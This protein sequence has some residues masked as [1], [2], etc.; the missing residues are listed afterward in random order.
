MG[1]ARCT[2]NGGLKTN[3]WKEVIT[4]LD[5]SI[6]KIQELEE[7]TSTGRTIPQD[8]HLVIGEGK[9]LS[10]AVMYIDIC[11]YSG[12]PA[13]NFLE[14]A[15][16][17]NIFNLF[18]SEMVR[19]ARDYG[20]EIEK[21][22]GDGLLIYF[23]PQSGENETEL[24]KRS[25]A[26]GLTMLACTKNLINLI[27]RGSGFQEVHFRIGM[28]FG[29]VTIAKVGSARLFN[30]RVVI[31]AIANVASKML[32]F[33]GNDE[34][35]IGGEFL[36]RLPQGW[37][38]HASLITYNSGFIYKLTGALYPIYRYNGRWLKLND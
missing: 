11:N 25:L 10:V 12:W 21:N 29:P 32:K 18:L 7:A 8:E 27:L 24:C 38:Q 33:G 22:T 14:Q 15:D 31:G 34:V 30:S 37:S 36:K 2:G 4:R 13:G 19:I 26:C 9:Q 3:Y 20:G 35:V 5:E 16:V 28:D 17:L 23:D 1:T 6:K